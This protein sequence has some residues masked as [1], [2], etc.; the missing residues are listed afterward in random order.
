V[1]SERVS[2]SKMNEISTALGILF[3]HTTA[4]DLA[5]RDAAGAYLTRLAKVTGGILYGGASAPAYVAKPSVNSFLRNG[6]SGVPDYVATDNIPGLL[7]KSNSI[8]FA[9]GQTFSGTWADITGAT[10]NLVLSYTCTVIVMASVTGY[11]AQAG[12]GFYVR[13]NVN[14]TGDSGT[15]PFNG[16]EARNEALSYCYRVSGVI[17]GTRT[18][19][20]QCQADTDP[21]VVERGRMVALAYVE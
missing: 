3:P 13:A 8:D 17:A 19:K 5:Y 21:N 2:A 12:R 14:G 15:I 20:L 11:N 18:I 6:S 7:H 9:P 4:G 10:F 16:G 1:A